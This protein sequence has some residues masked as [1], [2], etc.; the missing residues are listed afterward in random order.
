[1]GN[2]SIG[3]FLGKNA[4]ALAFVKDPKPHPESFANERF[5]GVNAYKFVSDLRV[6]YLRHV[7]V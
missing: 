1:M 7:G 6:G 3:E 4:S 2:G 5:W